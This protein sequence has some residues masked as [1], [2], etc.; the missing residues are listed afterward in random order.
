MSDTCDSMNCSLCPWNF[1]SKNTG[2]GCHFLLQGIFPTQGLN[3]WF[4]C[5]LYWQADSLPLSPPGKALLN[6]TWLELT[7][8]SRTD[9]RDR[10]QW[11]LAWSKVLVP[12]PGTESGKPGWKSEILATTSPRGVSGLRQSSSWLST[13]LKNAFLKEAKICRNT[14]KLIIR[15]TTQ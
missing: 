9:H 15:D 13:P 2:I 5:L 10:Q 11:A 3:L 8:P 12:C 1:W 6:S 7:D 14:T 4:L